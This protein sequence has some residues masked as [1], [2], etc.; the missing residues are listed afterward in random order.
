MRLT[1]LDIREQQFRRVMRGLDPDEITTFLGAVASE[2][3]M[4]VTEN[5]DLRQRL[6]DLE[7]Q[8]GEFHS[9]EKALRNT[10]LTAERATAETKENAQKEA[11]LILR[12]AEVAAQESTAHIYSEI[13]QK[14]RELNELRRKKKDYLLSVRALAQSHLAMVESEAQVL[15]N[16]YLAE[17]Q[18]GTAVSVTAIAGRDAARPEAVPVNPQADVHGEV[19]ATRSP[20]YPVPSEVPTMVGGVIPSAAPVEEATPRTLAA[21]APP[22]STPSR[23]ATPPGPPIVPAEVSTVA[24]TTSLPQGAWAEAA[25]DPSDLVSQS[26]EPAAMTDRMA[27]HY[28]RGIEQSDALPSLLRAVGADAPAVIEVPGSP[29][30]EQAMP[31]VVQLPTAG[32]HNGPTQ[33]GR[34][35]GSQ[36]D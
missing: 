33:A 27:E 18:A 26:G 32:D 36:G 23:E 5:R 34:S 8:I 7:H 30:P 20:D 13:L 28:R 3:E 31:P 35:D 4:L 25:F 1:A 11:E 10:L 29:P 16:E 19:A 2:Y 21:T 14:H 12:Q 15:E 22:G 6:L 17:Q 24:A 9:M